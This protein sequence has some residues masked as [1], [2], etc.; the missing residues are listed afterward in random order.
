MRGPAARGLACGPAKTAALTP[1]LPPLLAPWAARSGFA[2]KRLTRPAAT[3][4]GPHRR[5]SRAPATG[6]IALQIACTARSPCA[7]TQTA[8][9]KVRRRY[10]SSIL[11]RVVKGELLPKVVEEEFRGELWS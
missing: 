5:S 11:P 2:H 6:T 8:A 10:F 4:T 7:G 1:L 9:G 3:S